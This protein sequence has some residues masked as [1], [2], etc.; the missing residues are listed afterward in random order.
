MQEEKRDR[1]VVTVD[2]EHLASVESVAAELRTRGM[3]VENIMTTL[4][5][6]TGDVTESRKDELKSVGG[7]TAVEADEEMHAL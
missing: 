1:V 4:G 3:H 2:D 7:V 5:I 6:I